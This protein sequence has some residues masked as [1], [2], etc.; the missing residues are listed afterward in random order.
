MKFL[1]SVLIALSPLV[2]F[3]AGLGQN[4]TVAT[5]HAG[6]D[7][8]QLAGDGI[9]GQILLSANDWWGVIRAAEDLAIDIGKVTGKNLTL[10]NW[11]SIGPST[12]HSKRDSAGLVKDSESSSSAVPTSRPSPNFSP[13]SW[14]HPG[15][16][17][18]GHNGTL[19]NGTTTT[20][21][22]IYQSATN[23]VNVS[24][25]ALIIGFTNQQNRTPSA[26]MRDLQD[27]LSIIPLLRK[28]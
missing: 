13:N 5:S 12:N 8:L 27:Q 11:G 25:L 15:P 24:L 26:Q 14:G 22:Y 4:A 9:D 28:P 20:V 7:F 2:P 21:Y 10:G 6:P 18:R 16:Q 19:S 3:A 23:F 17:S 1:N